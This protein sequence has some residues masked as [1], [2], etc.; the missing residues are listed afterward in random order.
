MRDVFRR[1]GR[2][3]F[4]LERGLPYT[5]WRMLRCPGTV[6]RRDLDGEA[7]RFMG[8]VGY[9]LIA[10]TLL[11]LVL[12]RMEEELLQFAAL[13]DTGSRT[14]VEVQLMAALGA[15]SQ[16][17]LSRLTFRF[18]QNYFTYLELL[19]AL[20][21]AAGLRLLFS[22]RT[23]AEWMV[24]ELYTKAQVMIYTSVLLTLLLVAESPETVGIIGGMGGLVQL[25][26]HV[27]VVCDFAGASWSTAVRSV[28]AYLV[29]SA[30][31]A[32]GILGLLWLVLI[33]A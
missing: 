2:V 5:A 1:V 4:E 6:A 31:W 11:F 19:G 18:Q 16:Q 29:G 23:L 13:Y 10:A 12:G 24:V 3:F 22:G 14:D 9:F 32:G 15:D 28:G 20:P 33:L 26:M 17:E 8:P 7:R 30:A 25:G 27:W 21:I